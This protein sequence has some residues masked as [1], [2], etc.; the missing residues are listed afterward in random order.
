LFFKFE[1]KQFTKK[2][3]FC[4]CFPRRLEHSFVLLLHALAHYY[5]HAHTRPYS[6]TQ[7]HTHYSSSIVCR[8][9]GRATGFCPGRISLGLLAF[10]LLSRRLDPLA[11]GSA[12]W[13]AMAF[14]EFVLRFDFTLFSFTSSCGQS[15]FRYA[16]AIDE[17]IR[18]CVLSVTSERWENFAWPITDILCDNL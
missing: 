6:R 12:G 16:K 4:F 17:S 8:W 5:N 18:G 1:L 11:F 15:M 13:A 14:R 2:C 3:P 10:S 7:A 9:K